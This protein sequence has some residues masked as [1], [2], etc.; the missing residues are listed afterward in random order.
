MMWLA[1][2]R[3][4]KEIET[5]DALAELGITAHCAKQVEVKR[6]GKRRKPDVFIGPLLPN[7]IFIECDASQYLAAIGL[8]HM[9]PTM[10]A[11]PKG[12]AVDVHTFLRRA[13]IEFDKRIAQ[14]DAGERL[15]EF[16]YGDL[17][18]VIDGPLAG[19]TATFKG[20]AEHDRGAFPSI[21]A[22][23]DMM[24]QTVP[25]RFDILDVRAAE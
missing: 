25:T 19:L 9:A 7:Y 6:V 21:V 14:I 15:D 20:I 24:G 17:L 11:I 13:V 5:Q 1:Y 10:T 16:R 18:S 2:A 3:S 22:D 4:G 23:V 8:K 12:D